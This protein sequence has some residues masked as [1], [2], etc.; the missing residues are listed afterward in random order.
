MV[1]V[2]V[3][4][5]VVDDDTVLETTGVFDRRDEAEQLDVCLGERVR[6]PLCVIVGDKELEEDKEGVR[7]FIVYGVREP[8]ELSVNELYGLK[9][10]YALC[11]PDPDTVAVILGVLEVVDEI[12]SEKVSLVDPL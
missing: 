9:V 5:T 12:V 2:E 8:D 3:L 10:V 7:V 4:D 6:R 11:V 1:V